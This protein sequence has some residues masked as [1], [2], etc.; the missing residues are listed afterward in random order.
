VAKLLPSSEKP[1]DEWNA[2]D[3][4]CRGNTV[5]VSINGVLQNE[6]TGTSANC[7]KIALQAEGKLIEF[8]NIYVNP[9]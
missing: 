4:E 9:L 5:K 3:I 7:G 2:C 8:R 1:I 6:V